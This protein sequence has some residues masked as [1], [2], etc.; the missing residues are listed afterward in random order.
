LVLLSVGAGEVRRPLI[1]SIKCPQHSEVSD[2]D[3]VI[4]AK[5]REKNQADA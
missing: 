1:E 5:K 2:D 3:G 4:Y